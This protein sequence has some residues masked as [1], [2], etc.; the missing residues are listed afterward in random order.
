MRLPERVIPEQLEKESNRQSL[1]TSRLH[2][3]QQYRLADGVQQYHLYQQVIF[4]GQEQ[5]LHTLIIQ[6][7]LAI[8]W[9]NRER[10]EQLV[11]QDLS[12]IPVLESQEHQ[13]RP[14][15]LQTQVLLMHE[16]MIC[17][18]TRQLVIHINVQ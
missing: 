3:T 13:R 12:G 16:Q 17:I 4:C 2:Q 5:L 18:L 9:Q 8:A 10:R 6:L 1:I 11:Q 15:Y 7:V 14:P